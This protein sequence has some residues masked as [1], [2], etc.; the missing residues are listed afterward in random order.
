MED[1]LIINKV[2]EV[3]KN[4]FC[5]DHFTTGLNMDNLA[6]WDSLKHISLIV[7]IEKEFNIIIE[8]M[9]ILEMI[10]VEKINV[11]VKKYIEK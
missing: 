3:F 5:I 1:N 7:E 4:T 6:E 2:E 9:D 10:S 11:I 8:H